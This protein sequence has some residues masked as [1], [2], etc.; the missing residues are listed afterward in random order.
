MSALVLQLALHSLSA[1]NPSCN[2]TR[3]DIDHGTVD[4]ETACLSSVAILLLLLV[5]FVSWEP[6]LVDT[7]RQTSVNLRQSAV[8]GHRT[9]HLNS[10]AFTVTQKKSPIFKCMSSYGIT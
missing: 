9:S 1:L 3:V 8:S 10:C 4:N 5:K 7:S 2:S 6:V